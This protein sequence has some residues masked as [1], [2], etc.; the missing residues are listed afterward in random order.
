MAVK[1]VGMMVAWLVDST[2]RAMAGKLVEAT[3][4]SMGDLMAVLLV[5]R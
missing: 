4:D 1:W 3:V 2:V 5:E